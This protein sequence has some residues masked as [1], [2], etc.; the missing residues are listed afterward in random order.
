M[1]G[2][3]EAHLVEGK[4]FIINNLLKVDYVHSPALSLLIPFFAGKYT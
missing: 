1:T 3:H 4:S 2:G